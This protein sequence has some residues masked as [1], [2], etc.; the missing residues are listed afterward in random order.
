MKK[1]FFNLD[2]GGITIQAANYGYTAHQAAY[3]KKRKELDTDTSF[4]DFRI[5]RLKLSWISITSPDQTFTLKQ[6]FY[7][8]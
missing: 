4:Q 8:K 2:F 7:V 5:F 1:C 3:T 6:T